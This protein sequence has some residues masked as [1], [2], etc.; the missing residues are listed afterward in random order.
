VRIL[1]RSCSARNPTFQQCTGELSAKGRPQDA[2]V[3]SRAYVLRR[4][5][6]VEF[7]TVLIRVHSMQCSL[8]LTASKDSEYG[9]AVAF[10]PRATMGG[11]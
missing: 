3:V 6:L 9:N 10:R 4:L 11:D 8:T 5:G 2:R 7:Y 1:G